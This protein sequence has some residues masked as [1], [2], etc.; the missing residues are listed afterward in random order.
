M[1]QVEPTSVNSLTGGVT[2]KTQ[3]QTTAATLIGV[4]AGYLAG[5]GYLGLSLTDWTTI[6]T[7]V[8]GIGSIL[9]PVLVTRAQSL[10]DTVGHMK[11]TTVVTDP[12]S[13]KALPNNPDVVA[14]TPEIVTAIKKAQ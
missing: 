5:K 13:A 11:N 8:L 2:N 1:S 6:L 10:K 12:E 7:A 14:A 3:L 9:W 4:G